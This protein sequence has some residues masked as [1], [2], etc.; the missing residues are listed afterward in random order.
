MPNASMVQSQCLETPQCTLQLQ[1]KPGQ[2]DPAW[3]ALLQ[4]INKPTQCWVYFTWM[5]LPIGAPGAP[6]VLGLETVGGMMDG[7]RGWGAGWKPPCSPICPAGRCGGWKLG[8]LLGGA[9][10]WGCCI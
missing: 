9:G 6:S 8:A 10:A 5:A 1:E 4:T 3:Q 7:P 2:Q